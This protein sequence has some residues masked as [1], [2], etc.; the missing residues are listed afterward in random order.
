MEP[1]P[2]TPPPRVLLLPKVPLLPE[3]PLPEFNVPLLVLDPPRVPEPETED[4]WPRPPL[5]DEEVPG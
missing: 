4:D 5:E 3:M 1:E 2:V